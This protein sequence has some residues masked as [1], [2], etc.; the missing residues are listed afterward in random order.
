MAPATESRPHWRNRVTKEQIEKM[1]YYI[2]QGKIIQAIK[3]IRDLHNASLKDAKFFIDELKIIVN[4]EEIPDEERRFSNYNDLFDFVKQKLTE[5][6]ITPLTPVIEL[7]D[8]VYDLSY[9]LG[10]DDGYDS[11]WKDAMRENGLSD[12]EWSRQIE[13][14][15]LRGYN[16]AK[17]ERK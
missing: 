7:F 12:N 8:G 1:K 11:G 6:E 17:M 16:R 3:E 9:D 2:H 5:M 13:Q 10:Q 4:Q 14:A 15:E